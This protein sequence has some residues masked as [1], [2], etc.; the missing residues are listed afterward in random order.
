MTFN[1]LASNNVKRNFRSYFAYFLSS[2]F[3]VFIFFS[4]AICLFHPVLS[5]SYS[6]GSTVYMALLVAEVIIFSF[7]FLFVLYSLSTFLRAR[8]KEFGILTILGMSKKEFNKLIFIENIIIGLIS[9][10]SGLVLGLVFSKLFLMFTGKFLG[11]Q[12]FNFYFPTKAIF[13]TGISFLIIFIIISLV[14]PKLIRTNKTVELLNAGKKPKKEP[15]SS[16]ILSLLSIFMIGGGYCIGLNPEKFSINTPYLPIVLGT[17][18]TLL[19]FS[20][21]S[22]LVLNL[23]KRDRN[24]YL[25][26][27]NLLW[28]SNLSY[29]IRDNARMLFLVTIASTV[30][31]IS[32]ATL[33]SVKSNQVNITKKNFPFAFSYFSFENNKEEK[34]HI[35]HI[36]ELL[37]EKGFKYKKYSI[38][39]V[40]DTMNDSKEFYAIKESDFNDL[41]EALGMRTYSLNKGEAVLVNSQMYR[42]E[43]E[44]AKEGLENIKLDKSKL[45]LRIV[46]INEEHIAAS[47]MLE[48][49]IVVND[50][51]FKDIYLRGE[52][53][54]YVPIDIKNWTETGEVAKI[55]NKNIPIPM[56]KPYVFL[57]AG[58]MYEVEQEQSNVLLYIG[59]FIA[60]IFF[61]GAG[62][63]LYFRFYN[64]LDEDREKY[65]NMAKLGLTNKELKK[66]V[67]VE[68][69][70]LF[71][72]PYIV[73]V[74]HTL[75]SVK[76]LELASE[77]FLTFKIPIVL[78]SFFMVQFIYFLGIRSRYIKHLI[79]YVEEN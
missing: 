20:Q 24:L 25:K 33:Y 16:I 58:D 7:S 57:T 68:I 78:F 3:S 54:K 60:V 26:K 65:K 38:D 59:F 1:Q 11:I 22:V 79:E 40:K 18:G 27:T 61:V 53:G 71:F 8:K 15:K 64:D 47:G 19:F 73:A 34:Q 66:T 67:T 46:D 43:W 75:F 51:V 44:K 42:K 52:Q 76:I 31:F 45:T 6:E 30:A 55:L 37:K 39:F 14:T 35:N 63:F 72:I 28:I 74:I 9:I 10:F 77:N 70:T 32:V 50:E 62:S 21:F 36:D 5:N 23:F 56:D 2:A 49:M 69:A 17:A 29:K 48:T 13:L 41:A 4:F 12:N